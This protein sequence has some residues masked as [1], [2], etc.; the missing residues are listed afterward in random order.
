MPESHH[1]R[2]VPYPT[3]VE[4]QR[5]VL[6]RTGVLQLD[7]SCISLGEKVMPATR[8]VL[9][10]HSCQSKLAWAGGRGG[11]QEHD[12]PPGPRPDIDTHTHI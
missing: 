12:C 7:L 4:E 11:C 1:Q 9:T 8:S 3:D 6:L 2:A 10:L 5:G